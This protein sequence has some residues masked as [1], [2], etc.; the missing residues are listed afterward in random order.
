MSMCHIM[1]DELLTIND[2][3]SKCKNTDS[4]EIHMYLW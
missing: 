4:V 2:S 1:T 3:K